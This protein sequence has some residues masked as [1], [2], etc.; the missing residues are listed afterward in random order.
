MHAVAMAMQGNITRALETIGRVSEY[1]LLTTFREQHPPPM[2]R[3]ASNSRLS[4]V[5][6][7]EPRI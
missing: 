7:L 6:Y 5:R 2:K 3:S 4:C 1:F